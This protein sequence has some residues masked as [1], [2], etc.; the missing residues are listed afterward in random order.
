MADRYTIGR[1]GPDEQGLVL[2]ADAKS[3]LLIARSSEMALPHVAELV[4]LANGAEDLLAAIKAMMDI[5]D[6]TDDCW[7]DEIG[8]NELRDVC[9]ACQC[10][11]AIAKA[12][13]S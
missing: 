2:I 12:E 3:F 9:E 4:R 11:K 5:Q 10:R 7:C 6:C 8:K 1:G 13:G